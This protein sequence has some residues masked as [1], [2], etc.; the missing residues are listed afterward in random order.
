LIPYVPA[1]QF[2][3]DMLSVPL[4]GPPYAAEEVLLSTYAY[5]YAIR[6]F[7][8]IWHSE[9]IIQ[10]GP[11]YVVEDYAPIEK[12]RKVCDIFPGM[13]HIVCKL[14][15]DLTHRVRVFLTI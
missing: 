10:W 2:A 13:G 15:D 12:Y 5:N 6:N 4:N 8:P 14:P 9:A 11:R 7:I 3:E 1:V